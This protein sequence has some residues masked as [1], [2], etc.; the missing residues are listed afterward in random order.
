LADGTAVELIDEPESHTSTLD[1]EDRATPHITINPE[2][3]RTYLR[4]PAIGTCVRS[5]HFG[6]TIVQVVLYPDLRDY[7]R[8]AKSIGL[9]NARMIERFV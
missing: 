5:V 7:F 4:P 1:L 6:A 9:D 8:F 2:R 3:N